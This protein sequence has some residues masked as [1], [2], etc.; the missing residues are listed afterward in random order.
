LKS[1]AAENRDA[2]Y[3]LGIAD[4]LI[5]NLS[6]AK[7]LTVRPLSATQGYADGKKDAAAIGR[8]QKVD[9]VFAS[10]YQIADGKIRITSQLINVPTGAVEEIFKDEQTI[11]NAFAVQDAFAANVGQ[12]LLTR[13]NRLPND[14]AAVKRYTTS[15]E[16]YRLYLQGRFLV[17]KRSRK[18]AE[19]AIQYLEQAV[20]IDPNY[21]LAYAVLAN[22][23]IAAGNFGSDDL[24]QYAKAKAAAEKALAIDDNLAEAHA[25]AGEVKFMEWDFAGAEREFRRAVEL[26]PNS[27][28]AHQIYAI[29]LNS[30]GRFDEAI[31]A[32]TTAIDIEPTSVLNHRD[33]GMILCFARRPAEAVVVL[34]RAV[35]MDADFRTAYGWLIRAYR[36]KGDDDKAFEWFL[37]APHRKEES[38]EK[39][40]LW[41]TLYAQSG[42]RGI[43]QQRIEDAKQKDKE[44]KMP[45]LEMMQL[46]ADLGDKEQAIIH[47]EKAFQL[48]PRGVGL[49]WL[50]ADP[51]YDSIRDDPRFQEIVR[52]VGLK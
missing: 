28:A 16:A 50:K 37:R 9:Y 40:E 15:E 27:A 13:L 34:E 32:T 6:R 17:D 18:D 8:E 39:I 22:A 5:L 2:I 47:L 10:N 7:N 11:S 19:K 48:R 3:E 31:A 14:I 12:K 41:K 38:A 45:H 43:N 4:S 24:E 36:M 30:M 44:G 42:W 20:K 1:L 25:F 21:A 52:R 29:Y 26:N 23:R 46:Y 51:R 49:T 33:Y 35:E